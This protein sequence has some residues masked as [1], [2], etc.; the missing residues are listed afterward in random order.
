MSCRFLFAALVVC[1]LNAA[2][3]FACSVT[4]DYVRPTN[5][6]LVQMADAIVVA[7]AM[8]GIKTALRDFNAV[9]FRIDKIVKG[10]IAMSTT[11]A[12]GSPATSEYRGTPSD[13]TDISGPNP[14]AYAGPC[15]RMTLTLGKQYVVFLIKGDDGAFYQ[16]GRAFS[17]VNEDYFGDESLW[18]RTI[19]TYL[20]LQGR[21]GP[22]E[23]LD[24]LDALMQSKLKEPRTATALAE[25]ADI[26]DHLR[27]RSPWKPTAFLVRT[28]E[29]LERGEGPKYGVR[30]A[31]ADREMSVAQDLTDAMF[32]Q[33]KPPDKLSLEQEKNFVL[34]AL[35][36]GNH[37]GATPLFDRLISAPKVSPRFLGLAIRFYA[38]N[39]QYR[40]AY[41]L[42]ETQATRILGAIPRQEARELISDILDAQRGDHYGDGKERWR[43]DAYVRGAWPELALHL[44]WFSENVLGRG[45][46][47]SDIEAIQ[48]IPIKDYRERPLV[49]LAIAGNY[50]EAVQRWASVELLDEAKRLNWES[51]KDYV[52]REE[53][54]ARLPM[55]VMAR[56]YG[57]EREKVLHRVACQSERRRGLLIAALG[58][59]GRSL[60]NHWFV[61]LATRAGASD[62]ERDLVG[63]AL[64]RFY[65][66]AAADAS[67]HGLLFSG[68]VEYELLVKIIRNEEATV[69]GTK[70]EPLRCAK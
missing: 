62:Y 55:Q 28:F 56:S 13:P 47:G 1:C 70:V 7:T 40:R 27:S 19:R 9:Q 69:A 57:E 46:A 5:Y 44:Y 67:E 53:D 64:A 32:G 14:E 29:T 3:A 49:T 68:D 37:P 10:S 36:L 30:S 43:G 66:Q 52:Y 31:A 50:N 63:R 48:S 26:L 45:N 6:E 24:A 12:A 41:A 42:I 39:N 54:P 51:K 35:V 2:Q 33:P 23:Q 18:M 22:M 34:R 58:D 8:K 65:A 20:D 17:R 38:K 4:S 25:A 21:Y 59:W 61:K 11:F 15:N 16:L 60:D